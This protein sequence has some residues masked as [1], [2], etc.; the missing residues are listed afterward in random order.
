MGYLRELS[1][2]SQAKDNNEDNFV[3]QEMN[4]TYIQSGPPINSNPYYISL[5][6]RIG[7]SSIIPRIY[8]SLENLYSPYM[9]RCIQIPK[10]NIHPTRM[11]ISQNKY[12]KKYYKS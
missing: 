11:H 3:M 7:M 2:Y 6:R 4:P 5:V 12:A 9:Q 8:R 10:V 1:T